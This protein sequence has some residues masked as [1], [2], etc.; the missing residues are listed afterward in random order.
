MVVSGDGQGGL[1]PS[2]PGERLWRRIL[3]ATMGIPGA[4]VDRAGFLKSQLTNYCTEEQVRR[5][6]ASRPAE[7]GI[8]MVLID[9]LADSC[10][11]G[12]VVKASGFSFVT[13]LPGGWAMA[14]TIP[15]DTAQ[16]YWHALVL[17]QKLAYLYGWPDLLEQGE[18][19]EETELRLTLLI[20][21]MM[22]A[23]A[24]HRVLAEVSERFAQQAAHRLPRRALTQYAFYN[25]AKRVG[26]LIGVRITKATFARGAARVVPVLGGAVSAGVTAGMMQPM[27]KRLKKHLRQ[28]KYATASEDD[29]F[30]PG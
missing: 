23:Q 19:D 9:K 12:H 1:V 21:A 11:K 27:A 22:G 25:V 6:I 17:S 15:A 3:Q 13:G 2:T 30:Q 20:G 29:D 8:S 26:R 4:R 18:L 16:F 10:I 14:G 24:A 7:A 28:L 5:S